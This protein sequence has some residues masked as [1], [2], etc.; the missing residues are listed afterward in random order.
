MKNL[1]LIALK[2]NRG[3]HKALLTWTAS[4]NS[5]A[6]WSKFILLFGEFYAGVNQKQKIVEAKRVDG[7]CLVILPVECDS[8]Q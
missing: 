8:V 7:A 6:A 3:K 5:K 2:M 1:Y 4:S